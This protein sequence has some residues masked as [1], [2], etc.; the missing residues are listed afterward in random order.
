[1][2]TLS[3][4]LVALLQIELDQNSPG[5]PAHQ[6]SLSAGRLDYDFIDDGQTVKK[7]INHADCAQLALGYSEVCGGL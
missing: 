1:M 7:Y 4:C 2:S 3:W 5:L 6:L